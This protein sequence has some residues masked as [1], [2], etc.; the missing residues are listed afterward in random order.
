MPNTRQQST[1]VATD[2]SALPQIRRRSKTERASIEQ[3][4][5]EPFFFVPST[6]LARK[7]AEH[8]IFV[9]VE[10]VPRNTVSWY[11]PAIDIDDSKPVKTG[12]LLA[13]AQETILFRQ[14][15][16]ARMRVQKLQDCISKQ[17]ISCDED[18]DALLYWYDVATNKRDHIVECNLALVLAM[19]KRSWA[20][21]EY[22][23]LVAEGNIAMLRCVER[24]DCELGYKFSTYACRALTTAFN[25]FGK[26]QMKHKGNISFEVESMKEPMIEISIEGFASPE[27]V[28]IMSE[29]VR[30]VDSQ[31][32]PVEQDVLRYRFGLHAGQNPPQ[33]TLEKAGRELGIS[34]ERVRQVQ[35]RALQKIRTYI[36]SNLQLDLLA[37]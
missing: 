31:L 20:T 29:A 7:N 2:V 9:D 21:G 8:R 4:L 6:L 11:C 15:N 19:A 12:M 18:F 30:S 1:Q 13:R 34:K 10:E 5:L 36:E 35:I 27:H 32:T 3:I 25:R 14:Y 22:A 33:L 24:F 23:D 37:S 28:S 17:K 26:K 16:F